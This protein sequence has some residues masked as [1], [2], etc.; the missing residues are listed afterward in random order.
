MVRSGG[1]E[2]VMKNE[3][4]NAAISQATGFGRVSVMKLSWEHQMKSRRNTDAIIRL[5]SFIAVV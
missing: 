1:L 4:R 3:K 5:G 2:R